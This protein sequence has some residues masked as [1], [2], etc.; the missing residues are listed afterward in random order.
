MAILNAAL[1]AALLAGTTA[2]GDTLAA[3][4]REAGGRVGA[5]AVLVHLDHLARL[6]QGQVADV[7]PFLEI[8]R[9]DEQDRGALGCRR[10]ST[11]DDRTGCVVAAHCVD[12]DR[13][14]HVRLR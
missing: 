8:R 2:L 6:E 10:P 7:G 4:A 14:H 9:P 13:Q 12:R 1:T 11:G 3:I 5:A